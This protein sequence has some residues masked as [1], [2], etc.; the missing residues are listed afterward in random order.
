MKIILSIVAFLALSANTFSNEFLEVSIFTES[1]IPRVSIPDT[2]IIIYDLNA[3]KKM[4][5]T[6]PKFSPDIVVA[7]KQARQWMASVEGKQYMNDLRDAYKGQKLIT[8]WDIKKTPAVVFG[9]G[10]Y[11]VYGTDDVRVAVREYDN[12]KK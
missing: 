6:S 12:Y 11:V 9:D 8:E 7:E 10:Q 4:Q 2:Q 5:G 3:P 1:Q